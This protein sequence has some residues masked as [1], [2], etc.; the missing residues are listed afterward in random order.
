MISPLRAETGSEA[1]KSMTGRAA[2]GGF[3]TGRLS[4]AAAQPR[5][6]GA[7]WGFSAHPQSTKLIAVRGC[8]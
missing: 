1:G 2:E 5:A 4:S 7:K 6:A 3:D 8:F